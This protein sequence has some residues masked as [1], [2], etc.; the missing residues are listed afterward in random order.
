M[1]NNKLKDNFKANKYMGLS[2][3]E[4]DNFFKTLREID[5]FGLKVLSIK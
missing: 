1:L 4:R 3:T 5:R 2:L